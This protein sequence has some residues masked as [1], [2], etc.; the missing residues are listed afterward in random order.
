MR[1]YKAIGIE[2]MNDGKL[3]QTDILR[4]TDSAGALGER[5]AL[6]R[7]PLEETARLTQQ[8]LDTL[9]E[10]SEVPAGV[11]SKLQELGKKFASQL[12]D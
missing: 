3:L 1:S 2:G 8:T 11:I 9:K 4:D 6:A 12:F 7:G 10:S 5:K